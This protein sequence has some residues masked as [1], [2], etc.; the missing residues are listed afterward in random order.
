MTLFVLQAMEW[1]AAPLLQPGIKS[2]GK[3]KL[4]KWV[5]KINEII[6][7]GMTEQKLA[8]CC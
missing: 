5:V 3:L 2:W 8:C 7:A 1:N 4:N 6:T